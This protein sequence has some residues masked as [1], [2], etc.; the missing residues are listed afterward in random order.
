MTQEKL[1]NELGISQTAL[2]RWLVNRGY[3]VNPLDQKAIDAAREHYMLKR[4]VKEFKPKLNILCKDCPKGYI[5]DQAC[6]INGTQRGC[7]T[8]KVN[9]VERKEIMPGI[10]YGK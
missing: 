5:S 4:N 8:Y 2:R 9:R 10:T 3:K 7:P 1:A 6:A